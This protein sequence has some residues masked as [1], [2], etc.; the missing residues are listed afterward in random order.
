MLIAPTYDFQG[1]KHQRD[2]T[3]TF[4]PFIL[5]SI[6]WEA[7]TH[8]SATTFAPRQPQFHVHRIRGTNGIFTYI[9]HKKSTIH[10]GKCTIV[11][12]F[13][14]FVDGFF[15]GQFSKQL[16]NGVSWFPLKGGIG[17]IYSPNWQYIPNLYS[18]PSLDDYMSP[19]P[20]FFQ[21]TRKLQLIIN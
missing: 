21:G 13:L 20:P 11:T 7:L 6:H 18:L 10:V 15:F 2:L 4:L 17:T 12:W 3:T 16:L 5:V 9:Y 1:I 8:P 19:I 14:F